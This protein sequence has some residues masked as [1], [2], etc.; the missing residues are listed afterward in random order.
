MDR[1]ISALAD[2]IQVGLALAVLIVATGAAWFLTRPEPNYGLAIPQAPALFETSLQS[3]ISTSDTSMTLVSNSLRGG[4][5]LSGYQCFTIDEGRSDAEF[6]CG[7][8]SGTTVSNLERGIDPMTGTSTTASLKHAHRVGANV[9]VTDFPVIQRLRH[10]VNGT[11]YLPNPIAYDDVSTSTLANHVNRQVLSTL[12]Y[13]DFIGSSGCSNAT[14]SVRGCGELATGAEAASSTSAGSTGARLILPASIATDTPAQSS[15]SA[16]K[17]VVS[18]LSGYIKQGWLNLT[19][20]FSFSSIF[21]TNASTTN[22]TSTNLSVT[23]GYTYFR[24]VLNLWPSSQGSANQFLKNDGSGNL[25]WSNPTAA[26][27]TLSTTTSLTVS[28]SFAT[29]TG[30]LTIPAGTLTASST[31]EISGNFTCDNTANADN[32]CTIHL[33]TS[34]GSTLA[35]FGFS[36]PNATTFSVFFSGIVVMDG[37]VSAQNVIGHAINR[38]TLADTAI[39]GGNTINIDSS[40]DFASSQTLVLVAQEGSNMQTVLTNYAL[41]VNP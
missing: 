36:G 4:S 14:E 19:Q 18:D 10:L 2:A 7:T 24:N 17:V 11:D 12:D 39:I 9:K 8:I 35:S 40:I 37:S 30:T 22:A 32:S 21:A 23:S 20:H 41:V 27:Y 6:V 33:R 34:S 16:S 3:R 26:R 29:S 15:V 1:H 13:V 31:I 28:S 25:S 5:S 38:G